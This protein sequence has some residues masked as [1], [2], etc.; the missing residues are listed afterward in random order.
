[1]CIS[2][3]TNTIV[4]YYMY[5]F[6]SNVH[7]RQSLYFCGTRRLA[8]YLNE[9]RAILATGLANERSRKVVCPKATAYGFLISQTWNTEQERLLMSSLQ[10]RSV[11]GEM[12]PR[13]PHNPY[14]FRTKFFSWSPYRFRK[15]KTNRTRKVYPS[16]LTASVSI[17]A[18][19]VHTRITFYFRRGE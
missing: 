17:T 3:T 4:I 16:Y 2:P 8:R 10:K 12:I 9:K 19:M 18:G 11:C 7:S 5:T 6:L 14:G 1:M 15:K 13:L